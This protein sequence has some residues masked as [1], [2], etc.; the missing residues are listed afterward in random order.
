M[1]CFSLDFYYCITL[2][3]ILGCSH[4]DVSMA[5]NTLYGAK[6]SP[7]NIARF[8][9]RKLD[10]NNMCALKPL[11]DKWLA[12]KG[13]TLRPESSSFHVNSFNDNVHSND[14][15]DVLN[16]TCCDETRESK[17]P[18]SLAARLCTMD[19][20][21]LDKFLYNSERDSEVSMAQKILTMNEAELND[22]IA[23]TSAALLNK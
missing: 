6:S 22:Y 15:S 12:T 13:I 5:L 17:V 8:E 10:F 18:M 2:C 4:L 20:E 11:L 14:A 21:G 16:Y 23:S 1:L 7:S 3:F 9:D 19:E